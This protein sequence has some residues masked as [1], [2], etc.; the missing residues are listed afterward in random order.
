MIN[1]QVLRRGRGSSTHAAL[2]DWPK[3]LNMAMD[4][5]K[6]MLHLHLCD[7]PIIHRDLKSPNL[8]VDK[9]WRLKVRRLQAFGWIKGSL[10]FAVS[11]VGHV[12]CSSRNRGEKGGGGLGVPVFKCVKCWN[13]D[14]VC[15]DE[16]GCRYEGQI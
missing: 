12:Y 5:A 14:R 9:H 13:C 16:A 6:G 1:P 11:I 7:P 2:L 8:L 3:R 4:A 10:Y 15:I